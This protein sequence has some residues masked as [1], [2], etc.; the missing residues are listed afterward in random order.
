VSR[1][2]V[3]AALL[4]AAC[5]QAAGEDGALDFP[6]DTG[7][8]GKTDVF[9][10]RLAGV[11]AP[12]QAADLDQELLVADHRARREAAWETVRKVLE[13]VPLLGLVETGEE[14]EEVELPE[15]EVPMVPRF[16]T[17]YGVD[18]VKRLFQDLYGEL[19]PADRAVRAPF[20]EQA[21]ADAIAENAYALDRSQ[22]WP[23]ERYL[24]YVQELGL[25]P[26]HLSADEC[27]ALVQERL[28]GAVSGTARILY[29]PSAVTH[30]L[31]SYGAILGCLDDLDHLSTDATPAD[32]A[33][34]TLCFDAEFPV[35]SVLIKTQWARADFG[36]EIPVYDTDASALAAH[37]A[38]TAHWGEDGDRRANPS[39]GDILTLRLRNGDTYRLVGMHIM[40]KELRHWQWISLWWSDQPGT[41]FG[42]DRPAL[43]GVAEVWRN[44]KMCV[45][46]GYTEEDP[47]PAARFGEAPSL[48]AALQAIDTGQGGPTWCSNPYLEHGRG[49]ARTN[50]I[51]CHQHGGATVMGDRD[52]DGAL[53]PLDLEAIISDDSW[54]P[55]TGRRQIRELFPADYLYS[56]NRVDDLAHVISAE[57]GYLDN[58]DSNSVRPRVDRV[59]GLEGDA[60]AGAAGFADRCA[61][62]HGDTGE[63]SGWAP[64]LYTRVPHRDDPSLL[65]TLIL[66]RGPMPSWAA[67]D[68]Q[69]LADLLAQL[70]ATFGGE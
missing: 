2:A 54:F 49:N 69:E 37:L 34:F 17:W 24:R 59:L 42:A 44:Y 19:A 6:V 29:S 51:G 46:D 20:T 62:C 39:P 45:V 11:A 65:Q 64:N 28:T 33:N 27:A 36:R 15:G 4:L 61:P 57:V 31:E 8:G 67:L 63:G 50:C 23:L 21:I 30:T 18:D 35:D 13:P 58:A 48:E 3:I 10:R 1:A 12:Y 38:G 16:L 5:A 53:D 56:F 55:D 22:R 7:P 9:G 70:R 68:D 66:G 47:D 41:D 60:A 52:G 25:C 14:H 40:T 43:D 26:D 32:D